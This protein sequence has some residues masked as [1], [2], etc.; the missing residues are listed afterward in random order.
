MSYFRLQAN[1][2][3]KKNQSAVA[4]A[5]YRSGEELYSERDEE[6]KS[7]KA[8]EV[9]PVSF[10]LKPDHA[11][12]WTLDREKLWN[13]VE[14]VEKAWNA[15]LAREVLIALPIELND[16][17]QHKLV[18]SFVQEEFVD[19]G[20]VADVSI[21]RDKVHN[22]HA[23]VLLTIR[24]FNED[25]SW[26]NKKTRQYEFDQKGDILRDEEGEKVFQTVSSTDWNDRETLVRW[27]LNY[28]QAINQSFKEHGIDQTVSA[29]SFEE[30]GL[31]QIAEVRLD[32][33]EYQFVKRMEEQGL[34]AKTFYHQMN[35]EIRKTNA[36][37][38]QLN[39]KIIFLSDKQKT[40]DV[41]SILHRHTAEVT[42]QLDADY[43]KSFHFMKGRLKEAFS[44]QS[45]QQQ[46]QGLYQWE[47]RKL[48]PRQTEAKVSHAILSASHRA[49]QEGDKQTLQN[50]GFPLKDFHSFFTER[51]DAFEKLDS[52]NEQEAKTNQM[53]TAHAERAFR[54][55]CLIV[56]NS[57]NELHPNV[58]ENYLFNDRVALY[59]SEVLEAMQSGDWQRVP[60]PSEM[61]QELQLQEITKTLEQADK[62]SEQI[63]IQSHIRNK[64]GAEK[65]TLLKTRNAHEAI[66]RTSIK[67]NTAQTLISRYSEKA[68]VLD[69][70]LNELIRQAFPDA[71]EKLIREV[72]KLPL[73]MKADLL[74]HYMQNSTA[75][76]SP[77][78][79]ECMKFARNEQHKKAASFNQ[80]QNQQNNPFYHR[81]DEKQQAQVQFPNGRASTELLDQLVRQAS[82]SNNYQKEPSRMNKLNRKGRNTRLRRDLGLEIEL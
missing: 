41:Q 60:S 58:D 48:E 34:E 78:L 40:V 65:D 61:N 29:L 72:E 35:Q 43:A 75:H 28:A 13:E 9:A 71:K 1:I 3:S 49:Y 77:H 30:Q 51:L 42:H 53:V 63:R 57:F 23:H 22:P 45:V 2:I 52:Q 15:Q 16:E 21:H 67:L 66:Y 36:E 82:D 18:R 73:E 56:H 46:L 54:I 20:M 14:K 47:E 37:I 17:Q 38:A 31:D 59:K 10:L 44:F 74:R 64:L 33:N 68:V 62:V 55:Q 39:H 24:P 27:R 80:Y 6:L 7:F 26:G 25:G 32:R 8:R 70:Q 11:P 4:S 79:K 5:S 76:R 81:L 50:Q 69:K 19:A 12:E